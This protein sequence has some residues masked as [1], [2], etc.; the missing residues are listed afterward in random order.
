MMLEPEHIL[1][2][3]A[4]RWTGQ[5]TTWLGGG[6]VW[7]MAFGLK[8]PVE[9]EAHLDWAGVQAWRSMWQGSPLGGVVST[10]DRAWPGLG[11]QRLPASVSFASPADVA[12][13]LGKTSLFERADLR[14]RDRANAWPDLG[15]PLRGVAE[16]MAGLAEADYQRFVRVVDWLSTHRDSSLYLRQL[17]VEG[18]DTKW[19]EG[20][21]GPVARLLAPRF[22]RS[23][24]T[25]AVVA[26]L[27]SPPTRRRI[28]LLDPELRA[29]ARGM[30]DIELPLSELCALNIP[31]RVALVVENTISSHACTDL[32]GTVLIMGGGFAVTE[33]GDVPWLSRIPIIYWGDIDTWGFGILAALRRYHPATVS[34]LMDEET[35]RAHFHLRSD[36]PSP[37][38]V[39]PH[40]LTADEASLQVRLGAGTARGPGIRLEQERLDWAQAWR[41]VEAAVAKVTST[42]PD[43]N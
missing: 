17:P 14:Y 2:R 6:G 25:L 37:S 7:P 24:A 15:E 18:L 29:W 1:G 23:P 43:V 22:G 27:K 31:A 38:P 20:H 40:G 4:T 19:V 41:A 39:S 13:A 28:R 5:W 8:P 35:L 30:S 9:R 32:P 10:I 26:G 36:E 42:Q 12:A 21:A 3:L 34:C 33:L 11:Q 16:W